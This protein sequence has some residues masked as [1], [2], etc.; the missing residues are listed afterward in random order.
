[1]EALMASLVF[2]GYMSLMNDDLDG[3]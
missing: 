1:V 2:L 3:V